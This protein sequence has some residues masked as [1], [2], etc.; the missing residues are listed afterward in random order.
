MSVIVTH[1]ERETVSL[2]KRFAKRLR[3]GDVVATYGELGTGK[4]RFIKG[5]CEGLGVHKHVTSP[6]FTIIN[7]YEFS[8]GVV[9]H[10]DFYRVESLDEIRDTG[11]EEYL[12]LGGICLIEW[13]DRV[14]PLLPDHRYDVTFSPGTDENCRTIVIEE[15]TTRAESKPLEEALL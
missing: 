2:G 1:S 6:T 3:P 13:A 7:E 11:F 4:T 5:I 14:R 8:G 12:T 10:L 15:L 9:Y